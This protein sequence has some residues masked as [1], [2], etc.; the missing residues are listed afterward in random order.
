MG[1]YITGIGMI[2][3]LGRGL[4]QTGACLRRNQSGIGPLTLFEHTAPLPVG[5]IRQAFSD[6]DLPRTHRIAR[7]AAEDA[8]ADCGGKIP[9]AVIM[10]VTTG[11]MPKTELLLKSGTDDPHAYQYH[12]AG[13]VAESIAD[14]SHCRGP[15]FTVST[16]CSSGAAAVALGV[17]MLQNGLAGSVLAG[18]ADALCRMTYHGFNA[19]QLLSATGAKPFD[20]DRDG[21]S[22]SEGAAM[23]FLQSEHTAPDNAKAEMLGFGLS[24]DAYHA[25][26]PHPE[27][28][29]ARQA[30]EAAIRVAGLDPG[31]IDYI[32]LHGT[33]TISNDAAEARAVNSLFGNRMPRLSSIKGASGHSLAAAG[34]IELAVSA[35]AISENL[36]PANHAMQNPDPELGVQPPLEPETREIQTVLSN[37]FGFGGN[38]AAL[39]VGR[40]RDKTRKAD[41]SPMP[42][43]VA[44]NACLT[45]AG[46]TADTTNAFL[47]GKPC[48]GMLGLAEISANLPP[49]AV[50]RLKRLPRLALSLAREALDSAE[51]TSAPFGVFFATGWGALTETND[52]LNR[53]FENQ[54][55]FSSPMDFVG[56]VHNAPA[57]EI[58]MMFGATGP[59]IT[60]TGGDHSFE[61]ALMAASVLGDPTGGPFLVIGADECHQRLSPLFDASVSSTQSLCDGGGGLCLKRAET[62]LMVRPVF[63][64]RADEEKHSVQ[65]LVKRLGGADAVKNRFGAIFAGIPAGCRQTG[66]KQVHMFQSLTGSVAPVLDYRKYTGQFASASAAAVSLAA[67]CVQQDRI[68]PQPGGKAPIPLNRGAVLVLGTGKNLTAIEVFWA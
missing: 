56:S 60:M 5:E 47:E 36:V 48:G 68:P 25:A 59:N 64:R 9:E 34:A 41:F 16:A 55:R 44:G 58:A 53:L 22:L 26:A 7:A 42:M 39:A 50:R 11:G 49:R 13:S 23:L 52:F 2:T 40:P 30:M 20:R 62:G 17:A 66:E 43:A 45:G 19:L 54:E 4:R 37:S 61:Q 31:D 27:G 33:G 18:G 28:R 32:N 63:F 1:I 12:A 10:G 3:A 8:I 15:V 21:M 57:G 14:L 35:I 51:H 38:N 24:C 46:K 29:G 6:P 67:A 65:S